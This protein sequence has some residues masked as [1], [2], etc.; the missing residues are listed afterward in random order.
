MVEYGKTGEMHSKAY[1]LAISLINVGLNS[2]EDIG[3]DSHDVAHH[4]VT[5]VNLELIEKW[6]S[7]GGF[8]QRMALESVT[9]ALL[10]TMEELD[11]GQRNNVNEYVIPALAPWVDIESNYTIGEKKYVPLVIQIL[12]DQVD[13]F[14]PKR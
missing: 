12:K 6:N 2:I 1:S 7:P 9:M 4:V 14:L 10:D 5:M 3:I 11:S 13:T 8:P